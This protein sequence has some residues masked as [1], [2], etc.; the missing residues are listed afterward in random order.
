MT[1]LFAVAVFNRSCQS[2]VIRAE[3]WTLFV[4]VLWCL[5][6]LMSTI[7][8]TSSRSTLTS[9]N[10]HFGD[11]KHL[12]ACQGALTL[13]TTAYSLHIQPSPNTPVEGVSEEGWQ[14]WHKRG[15]HPGGST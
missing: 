5:S 14:Q 12:S 3:A 6:Q 15:G 8:A 10:E 4:S 11:A 1:S 2:E 7:T 13:L 9:N